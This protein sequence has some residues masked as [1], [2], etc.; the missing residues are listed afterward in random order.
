[1][2]AVAAATHAVASRVLTACLARASRAKTFGRH[3]AGRDAD[4]TLVGNMHLGLSG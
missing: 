1:V 4:Q 3:R 2:V